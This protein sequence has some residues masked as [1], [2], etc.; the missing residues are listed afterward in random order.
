[1][2]IENC[3]PHSLD[4]SKMPS[5]KM[6]GEKG[7]TLSQ[8][9]NVGNLKICL[10]KYSD[11]YIADHWCEKGHIIHILKGELIIEYKNSTHIIKTGITHIVG[12]DI[13]AHKA[14]SFIGATVLIVD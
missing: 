1:M 7:Y 9:Q 4:W 12:D 11:N 5:E 13:N 14:K 8:T 3:D 6:S 2:I 10:V